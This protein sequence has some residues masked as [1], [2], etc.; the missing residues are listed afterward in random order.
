MTFTFKRYPSFNLNEDIE[1]LKDE[2]KAKGLLTEQTTFDDIAIY[3]GQHC[4]I[5]EKKDEE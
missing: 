4:L 3:A 5:S 1:L 2:M